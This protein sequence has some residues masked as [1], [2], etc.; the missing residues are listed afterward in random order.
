MPEDHSLPPQKPITL[1]ELP[2]GSALLAPV[3]GIPLVMHALTGA[4]FGALTFGV[5]A[6]VVGLAKKKLL[7][8]PVQPPSKSP[9]APETPI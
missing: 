3:L 8:T 1:P 9:E 4:A 6:L 7:K 5:G 2:S